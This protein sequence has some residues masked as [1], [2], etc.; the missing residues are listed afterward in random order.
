MSLAPFFNPGERVPATGTFVLVDVF[1]NP[2]GSPVMYEEG[3][4]FRPAPRAFQW[5]PVK[6]PAPRAEMSG[7][8]TRSVQ[9]ADHLTHG[10]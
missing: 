7:S 6:E 1:G 4:V 3:D 9:I 8:R 10:R 2:T 5:Q